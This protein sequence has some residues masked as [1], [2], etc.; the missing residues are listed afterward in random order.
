MIHPDSSTVEYWNIEPSE[1]KPRL[2]RIQI[3]SRVAIAMLFVL[4]A[5]ADL[6]SRHQQRPPSPIVPQEVC[7]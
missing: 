2:S 7:R 3:A 5:G 4:I 6:Y 1:Y